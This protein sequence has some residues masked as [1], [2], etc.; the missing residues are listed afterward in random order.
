MCRDLRIELA[1][2]PE[3]RRLPWQAIQAEGLE[4]LILWHRLRP[5]VLDWLDNVNPMHC[6]LFNAWDATSGEYIGALWVS[7][8]LE[9]AGCLHFFIRAPFRTEGVELARTAIAEVVKRLNLSCVWGFTP[10]PYRHVFGM[11]RAVGFEILGRIPGAC[12]MPSESRPERYVDGVFTK[13]SPETIAS[14]GR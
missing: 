12:R 3:T 7:P 4:T 1:E 14:D 8:I 5:T 10:A 2:T 6:V 11:L 13:F 9:R